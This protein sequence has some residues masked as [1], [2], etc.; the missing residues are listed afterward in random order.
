M[1]FFLIHPK[2]RTGFGPIS[3]HRLEHLMSILL[4]LKIYL[5]VFSI[6]VEEPRLSNQMPPKGKESQH[7]AGHRN[8]AVKVAIQSMYL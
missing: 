5:V 3:F 8:F 7:R 1:T 6:S 4:F 2:S